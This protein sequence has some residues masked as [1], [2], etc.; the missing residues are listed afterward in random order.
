MSWQ[1][2][3]TGLVNVTDTKRQRTRDR[4]WDTEREE[5][6]WF[7]KTARISRNLYFL[8]RVVN[9]SGT[10][11]KKDP[12]LWYFSGKGHISIMCASVCTPH[13]RKWL[14]LPWQW[15]RVNHCSKIIY[16]QWF[17]PEG[18]FSLFG[19]W[20]LGY[21]ISSVCTIV[22]WNYLILVNAELGS[23]WWSIFMS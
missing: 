1:S 16:R 14:I 20:T 10:A 7:L 11:D 6:I 9:F 3:S 5:S 13:S 4:K 18:F 21:Q 2:P 17:E 12:V 15:C 23:P 19:W 22:P 8:L